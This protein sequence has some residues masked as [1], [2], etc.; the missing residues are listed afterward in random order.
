MVRARV[1]YYSAVLTFAVSFAGLAQET[2]TT[3]TK[4]QSHAVMTT[5]DTAQVV[6][7]SGDD[8]V[9][10]FPDGSLRLL[11]VPPGTSFTVDGQP[12]KVSDLK[13]GSVISHARV[14]SR[15]ESDVT[16]VTQING[17]VTAKSG[18]FV[19]LRLDDGTSKIYRVPMHATFTIDGQPSTF[20]N[21]TKGSKISATAVKTEGLSTVSHGSA[22]AAQ[23]PPQIGVLLIEKR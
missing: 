22:M 19:T 10:K 5:I 16:T 13:P 8:A 6:Y 23:T 1:F 14:S 17:T 2:T 18:P 15:T 9:L 3:T 11:E 4:P 12:A 21:L 7:V 20:A